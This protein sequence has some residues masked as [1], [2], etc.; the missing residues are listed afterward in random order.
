M[1]DWNETT[2]R[3]AASWK[4]FKE[5]K[6]LADIGAVSGVKRSDDGWSGTVR[7]GKRVYK[8]AVKVISATHLETRC[9]CPENQSTAALCAHGVASGLVALTGNA[10]SA[11]AA[12]PQSAPSPVVTADRAYSVSLP[13]NWM[14]SLRRGKISATLSEGKTVTA[15][16]RK[17]GAWLASYSQPVK[18]PL[19]VHPGPGQSIT[20][21]R[22]I[23]GHPEIKVGKTDQ[24]IV[25]GEGGVIEVDTVERKGELVMI[26]ASANAVKIDGEWWKISE[27]S[28]ER[29][30]ITFQTVPI[31]RL[32]GLISTGSL[33]LPLKEFLR[34][35]QAWQEVF[36]FPDGSWLDS[37]HFVPAAPE[38]DLTLDGSLTR[39]EA[40][41][42]VRYGSDP[43]VSP[44]LGVLPSL[45]SLSG[46]RCWV[47]DLIAEKSAVEQMEN[48]GFKQSDFAAGRWILNGE[49]AVIGYLAKR[50]KQ[51]PNHWTITESSALRSAMK[52][53]SIVEPKID[54]LGSGEDWLSFNL[55]FQSTDGSVIP[56]SEIRRLLGSGKSGSGRKVILSDD[57]SNLIEPMLQD[58]ELRQEG[59]HYVAS[60]RAGEV[61]HEIRKKIG[62]T[63]IGKSEQKIEKRDFGSLVNANLRSYQTSGIDWLLDRSAKFGGALL[64]DDMGLGKTIQTIASIESL[65]KEDPSGIVLVI[66]TAS[67]LGNWK[68]EFRK[69]ASERSV[70]ILH[71][72]GRDAERAKAVAG[73]VLL[74]TFG[75]LPRDLAWYLN[76]KFKAVVVDEASLMRNPDTDHAKA[77]AR[78]DAEVRIAL[79]GTPIENGVRDLWSIFR[80]IQPGWLGTREDFKERYEVSADDPKVLARLRLKTAP[81]MLRRTKEEVAPELPSKIYI[82]EY[83]DLSSQQQTVYRDLLIEGRKKV[84]AK[85]DSGNQGAARMQVLTA[86]LRLRQTCCDLALLGNDRFNQLGIGARSAKLE[87]L[88]ELISEAISGNHKILIFSQFQTQLRE[89]E[90]C[91]LEA[92][93]D[94]L[95]LDGQTTNRQDLVDRFQSA[96]GP[97]VFLISLKAGGYGLNLT[98]ADIVVHFDPWWNPAAE[99]QATDRAHRIGQTRPVTV[100]RMITRGT[101]EEKV[102]SLQNKKRRLASAI[103]E[104]GTGD[105]AGWSEEELMDLMKG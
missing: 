3:T 40:V 24:N 95:K 82:E 21:L 68:A 59:G 97:P 41:L 20:F 46:D 75:T 76:Q 53:V 37:I 62:K 19:P 52:Q 18:L 104:N 51:L 33:E 28:I 48:D 14:E 60:K 69:F 47:R 12:R 45:P 6:S 13:V 30:G 15:A 92:K 79:T 89:I 80:F 38:F 88:L 103:D 63:L 72:S 7:E 66:A 85:K 57:V 39:V 10:G 77:I 25:V 23:S 100:Y 86:L 54:I 9:A 105:A 78:L 32:D 96:D 17:L 73:D 4:A 84:E 42:K 61:I 101:V 99:A 50:L 29:L 70:R 5:G 55:S 1:A 16:D 58:L 26:R 102:I 67:L 81:F 65:L 98:A 27:T 91:L 22:A 90:K 49:D 34:D 64:A 31:D 56:A 36:S 83:C 43:A 35:L 2:L 93:I 8:A 94:S 11:V 87:R 44:G 71:G 74:T